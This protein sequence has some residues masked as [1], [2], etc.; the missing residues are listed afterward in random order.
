MRIFLMVAPGPLVPPMVVFLLS[1]ARFML[2]ISL[3]MPAHSVIASIG[4]ANFTSF[5]TFEQLPM[6]RFMVSWIPE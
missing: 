6:E 3:G 4:K 2:M 5:K 1:P